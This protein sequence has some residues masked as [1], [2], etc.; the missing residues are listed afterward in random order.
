[1]KARVKRIQISPEA[2]LHIMK[3]DTAWRVSKGVPDGARLRGFTI[4]PYANTLNVFVEH[5][6]FPLVDIQTVVPVLETEFRRIQ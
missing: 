2:F 3:D 5:E 6:S 4:D 1:M